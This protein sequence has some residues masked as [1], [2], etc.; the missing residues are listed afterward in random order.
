MAKRNEL[1]IDLGE[2]IFT[3]EQRR[4]LQKALHKTVSASL[5]KWST[6]K[7]EIPTPKKISNKRGVLTTVAETEE[8]TKETANLSVTFTDSELNSLTATCNGE[9]KTITR[10][11]TITF[12]NVTAGKRI[13]IKGDSL[14]HTTVTIDIEAS[15]TQMNFP[16]GHFDGSFF[17]L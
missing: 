15:P 5:K 7:K 13:K 1:K 12:D 6:A 3:N 14:G 16:A 9:A 10:S 8:V 17:I 11:G 4:D 2:I